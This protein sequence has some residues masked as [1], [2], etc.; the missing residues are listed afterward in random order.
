MMW[1]ALTLS[2]LLNVFCLWYVRNLLRDYFYV[3]D[4]MEELFDSVDSFSSHLESVHSLET[5]YGEPTLQR[6]ID[7]SKSVVEDIGV[8]RQA[9]SVGD[10]NEDEYGTEATEENN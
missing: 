8:Y 4:N 6:L 3:L 7:H 1:V 9:L 2:I 10:E 5:F